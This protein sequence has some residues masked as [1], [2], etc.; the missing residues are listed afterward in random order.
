MSRMICGISLMVLL[1]AGTAEAARWHMGQPVMIYEDGT[2]PSV[3]NDTVAFLDDNGGPVMY[4]DGSDTSLIYEPTYQSWEPANAGGAIAWRNSEGSA[5]SNEI[6]LWN[7]DT[8]VNISNAPGVID[9]DLRA[10][11]NGDLIWSQDHTW[12]YYYHAATATT[13]PL[14]IRGTHP[15]L[16]VTDTGVATYA[17]QDPD[18]DEVKYFDGSETQTLGLGNANGAFPAV[19]DGSVAWVGTSDIGNYF[20]KSEIYFWIDGITQRITNDDDVGGIADEYP[21][22]WNHTVVWSRG[23]DGFSSLKLFLWDYHGT[24]QLTDTTAKY[25]SLDNGTL[26]WTGEDGLYIVR[27]WVIGDLNFDND[28]DISDLAQLLG[29]WNTTEG[30]TYSDGDVD[31]DGDVDIVDLG[32]LLGQ[33][34]YGT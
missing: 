13:E 18:T 19:W 5:T 27:L 7:G 8:I 24:M 29:N 4:Y 22:L 20:T 14:N 16:Y 6:M 34:G 31:E 28:V 2:R 17:Y 11:N 32:E 23:I 10:G 25:A 1:A 3:W 15:A 30:A 33:Y 21:T 12:L 26:A 9:C